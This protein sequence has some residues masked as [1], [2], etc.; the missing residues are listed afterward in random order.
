MRGCERGDAKTGARFKAM[1][2][3][4]HGLSGGQGD[5][6]GAGAKGALP[7]A[8]PDP[9]PLA[10]AGRRDACADGLNHA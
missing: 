5:I 10:D 9:D 7:L 1:I 4:R 6:L 3:E 2:F 8:V